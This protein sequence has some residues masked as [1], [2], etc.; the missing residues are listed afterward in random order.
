MDK[1]ISNF[2]LNENVEINLSN[3]GINLLIAV[4]LSFLIRI[5]YNKYSQSLSNK[6][7][8]SK[9]FIVLGVT[10]CLVITIVKSSLALSLGLVGAL[11]IVRFRAAI[12][13]PEELIYLFLVIATGLGVGANQV[14]ITTLGVLVALI[15]II[16]FSTFSKKKIKKLDLNIFQLSFVVNKN[17]SDDIFSTILPILN[18]NCKEVDFIS[19]SSEKNELS[20]HFEIFPNS[21]KSISI[22]NKESNTKIKNLK[23]IFSRKGNISL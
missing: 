4:V 19:M 23:I 5:V 2:F 1:T 18:A 20:I 13:E 17:V 16:I 15:V 22:I 10:T 6:D 9:N 12:K 14:K 8:F 7:Y 21:A 3:F 11:S